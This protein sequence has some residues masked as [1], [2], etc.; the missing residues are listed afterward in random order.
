M[1]FNMCPHAKGG[2]NLQYPQKIKE[3]RKLKW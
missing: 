2:Y 1:G 3:A